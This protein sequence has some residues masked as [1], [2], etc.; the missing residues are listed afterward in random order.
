MSNVMR[1][2]MGNITLEHGV[3]YL[4]PSGRQCTLCSRSI[5]TVQADVATL[6]YCHPDGT[7]AHSSTQDGFALSRFNWYLL[8]AVG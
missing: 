6:L 7:P 3:R 4:A 2:I 5:G 1:R 8:R